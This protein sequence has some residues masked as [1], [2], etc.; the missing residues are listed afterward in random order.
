[1][2]TSRSTASLYLAHNPRGKDMAPKTRCFI[3]KKKKMEEILQYKT[4]LLC[5]LLKFLGNL[6]KLFYTSLEGNLKRFNTTLNGC[7]FEL[8]AK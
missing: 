3:E 7:I 6:L 1:M 4:H 8:I 2:G 5:S